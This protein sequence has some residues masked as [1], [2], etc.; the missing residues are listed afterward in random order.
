MTVSLL[1]NKHF[2]EDNLKVS[3][4]VKKVEETDKTDSYVATRT[5]YETADSDSE[6]IVKSIDSFKSTYN[7]F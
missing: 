6:P 7:L 2:N 4:D 5:I 1:G 3:I